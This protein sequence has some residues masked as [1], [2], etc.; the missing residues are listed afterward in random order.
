MFVMAVSNQI[1]TFSFYISLED[2]HLACRLES[3][4]VMLCIKSYSS[5][6]LQMND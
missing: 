3:K 5:K 1:E 2:M 6:V 4:R